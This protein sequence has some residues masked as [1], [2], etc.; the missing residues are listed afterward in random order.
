MLP[1]LIKQYHEFGLWDKQP[2]IQLLNDSLYEPDLAELGDW[3]KG[4][5]VVTEFPAASDRPDM[6]AYVAKFR[7]KTGRWPC[8]C[9][10]FGAYVATNIYLESVEALGGN[11]DDTAVRD[12][13]LSQTFETLK[14]PMAFNEEG[15]PVGNAYVTEV[16][17]MD[18][19]GVKDVLTF[20]PIKELTNLV[21]PGY[22]TK[23]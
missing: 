19:L 14:G 6:Q 21:H 3:T 22:Y 7:E 11:T 2:F 4:M 20:K 5:L 17:K 8:P 13:I 1:L 10:G 12:Y 16:V 9:I 15:Y 23:P 18:L